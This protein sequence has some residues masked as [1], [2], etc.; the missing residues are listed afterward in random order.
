MTTNQEWKLDSIVTNVKM[1]SWEYTHTLDKGK[2][3]LIER[4]I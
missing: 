3:K 1:V 2:F 4:T